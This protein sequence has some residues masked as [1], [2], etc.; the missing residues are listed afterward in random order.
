M[1][2]GDKPTNLSIH[3]Q[4]FHEKHIK[5]HRKQPRTYNLGL[6]NHLHSTWLTRAQ[7]VN[8]FFLILF[9]F[10]EILKWSHL[11]L[12]ITKNIYINKITKILFK[13]GVK[14]F[15]IKGFKVSYY[16]TKIKITEIYCSIKTQNTHLVPNQF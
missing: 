15:E 5:T 16:A 14:L 2:V 1:I 12:L 4:L 11:N 9:S 13:P 6:L 3:S 7:H 8:I 10:I